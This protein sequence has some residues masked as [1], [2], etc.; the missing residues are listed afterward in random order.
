MKKP[1]FSEIEIG[2][3]FGPLVYKM[4]DHFIKAYQFSLGDESPFYETDAGPERIA[5]SMSVAAK[6]LH[7]FMTKYDPNA[8]VALHQH[9]EVKFHHRIGVGGSATLR[10]KYLDKYVRRGKG[11]VVLEGRATDDD[12]RLLVTQTST[13][14]LDIPSD[15]ARGGG[16]AAPSGRRVSGV[17]PEGRGARAALASDVG[18]G[19][20]LPI[21]AKIA[22]QDQMTVFCGADGGWRNIHS[23]INVARKAGMSATVVPG[24]MQTCWFAEMMARFC[25]ARFF[26]AGAIT[27][28]YLRSVLRSEPVTC[29]GV[30]SGV[31][32]RDGK[33]DA[34]VECWASNAK[35][36]MVAV[37]RAWSDAVIRPQE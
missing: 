17:W 35:G 23:D 7:I 37:G 15:R 2:E 34:E 27:S 4:D 26:D 13:E 29:R 10:G 33:M 3:T 12:G 36:E 20:P 8:L 14:I 32:N 18:V 11:Y 22:H 6:L 9:E 30:V 1:T 21:L 28:T 5:P 16:G 25:G 19:D 24:M 31:V